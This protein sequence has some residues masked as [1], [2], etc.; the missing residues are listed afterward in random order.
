MR[1]GRSFSNRG[2]KILPEYH[3]KQ[4][5]NIT[6]SLCSYPSACVQFA[7]LI[8]ETE[9]NNRKAGSG[10]ATVNL[11]AMLLVIQKISPTNPHEKTQALVPFLCLFRVIS[12]ATAVFKWRRMHRTRLPSARQYPACSNPDHFYFPEFSTGG[13]NFG[14]GNG[15]TSGVMRTPVVNLNG[16]L[17][18]LGNVISTKYA[19]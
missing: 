5:F 17:P 7:T 8:S 1:Y 2:V 12:W 9:H 18:P 19:V 4:A 3:L 6:K 11:Q 15:S 13:V 10:K 16:Y 14:A